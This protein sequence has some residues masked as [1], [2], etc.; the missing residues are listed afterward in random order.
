MSDGL[1]VPDD[2]A[3]KSNSNTQNMKLTFSSY[4]LAEGH[5]VATCLSDR[6]DPRGVNP[7]ARV[8]DDDGGLGSNHAIAW[9]DEG[10]MLA[11][12]AIRG[13]PGPLRWARE[14]FFV[15]MDGNQTVAT[16]EDDPSCTEV[17]STEAFL[18]ALEAWQA[19]LV[20]GPCVEP[21][22]VEIVG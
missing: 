12:D 19:F 6:P 15:E 18:S 16:S 13:V 20:A 22:T 1:E 11:L 17:V 10:K 5:Y 2:W 9:I 4:P 14:Y 8:L 7:L 21:T 3:A